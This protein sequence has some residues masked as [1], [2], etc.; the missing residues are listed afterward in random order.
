[1]RTVGIVGAG[2]DK[3]TPSGEA[4]A[5]H[6]I[7]TIIEHYNFDCVVSGR[8]PLGGIDAWCI[9]EA[10]KLGKGTVEYPSS[11]NQWEGPG[12]YKE[13]NLKIAEASDEVYSIVVDELPS[14][15][16]GRRFGLCYHC[17]RD[18]HVKSGGCWTAKQKGSKG[19]VVIIQ[20]KR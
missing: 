6:L 17:G 2:A 10:K 4:R 5:R 18:D 20:N 3:F 16:N 14:W 13:R 1:V 11:T 7:R 9:E 19:H 15:Y 8:S 12:G